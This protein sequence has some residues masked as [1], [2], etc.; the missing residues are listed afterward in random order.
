MKLI[1]DNCIDAI[2][3]IKD[4]SIDLTVTSPPYDNL[5]TYNNKNALFGEPVWQTT[6]QQLYRVTK[7]GGVV[8]WVVADATIKGSETGTSFKQALYAKSCGFNLHDTMIWHKPNAMPQIDKTR[9]TQSFEYM[10]I[11]SK[12]KPKT[13]KLIKTLTK[14]GG[15]YLYRGDNNPENINKRGFNKVA[16][17]R[18]GFN[19]YNLFVGGKNYKHPAIFPLQL[20]EYHIVS[21]SEKGDTVLDPFM[22]SGTTGVACINNNRDYIGIEINT[23]YYNN[24]VNRIKKETMQGKLL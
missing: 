4:C 3:K 6:L 5:R 23:E 19:V 8:V 15:K 20:A 10:F 9:Y 2:P 16:K 14:N 1:N 18:I 17:K 22:G 21:W 7:Q 13:T 24:A 12:G 11:L